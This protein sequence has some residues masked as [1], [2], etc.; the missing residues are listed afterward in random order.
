MAR[1]QPNPDPDGIWPS[2]DD[3]QPG[4]SIR[5]LRHADLAA[6]LDQHN[7]HKDQGDILRS[8]V[9]APVLAV[10][11]RASVGRPGASAAAEYR[12]HR[13]AERVSD[14]GRRR[15]AL[16]LHQERDSVGEAVERG[17]G[18]KRR[19][20]TVAGKLGHEHPPSRQQE[21]RERDPV[22]G[23]TAEAMDEHE[24]FP[25]ARDQVPQPAP[26][27]L[28]EP[29]LERARPLCVRHRAG[30][31]FGAMDRPGRQDP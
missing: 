5:P 25:L 1:P 7:H 29:L 31:S 3:E 23:G 27:N 9:P 20:A 15:Q 16:P 11:V 6:L 8:G 17:R 10:R 22:R 26:S 21:R 13:T 28:G 30:L 19:R 12:R 18:R 14:H 4:V 2:C 24:R